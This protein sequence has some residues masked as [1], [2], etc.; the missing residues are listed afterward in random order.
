MFVI[1][2][3]EVSLKLSLKQEGFQT[4]GLKASLH[5]FSRQ[6]VL[7]I[8]IYILITGTIPRVGRL[9]VVNYFIVLVGVLLIHANSEKS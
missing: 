9:P 6:H 3:S 1:G 2:F 5:S 8:L 4:I 7:Y